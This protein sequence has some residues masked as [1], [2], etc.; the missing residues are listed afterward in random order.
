MILSGTFMDPGASVTLTASIDWGDGS[1]PT[2]V[3]LPP[4]SYAFS[5]PHDYTDDSVARYA[6]A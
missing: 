4:G 5:V 2:V 6:S 3:T 1:P